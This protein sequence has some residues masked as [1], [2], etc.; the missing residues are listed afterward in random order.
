MIASPRSVAIVGGGIA[1]L[2]CAL[3]LAERGIGVTV[4]ETRRKLGGRAT[5]FVDPRTGEVLDNCQHVLMGCCTNLIDFYA[6]LGVLDAIEWHRDIHWMNPPHAPDRMRPG[7]LPAPGH[8]TWSFLRMRMLSFGEKIAVARAMWRML[9]M[10]ASGRLAWEGRAFTEFLVETRQPQRVVDVFWSP[11]VVS[12]CN[13]D[14]GEVS[15]ASAMQVFQEGF[16]ASAE[17]PL[18]GLSTV[19]LVRLYDPAEQAIAAAGGSVRLGVSARA[20]AF[21]G[22]RVTGVVTDEGMVEADA[23]VAAVPADRLA[24]LVSPT[25]VR[26]DGRLAHLEEVGSSPILGVHLRFPRTVMDLPH[27][28]LPGRGTQWLFDKGCEPDGSQHV[29]AVISGAHEWMELDEMAIAA[30]VL[31]DLRWAFPAARG[32]EPTAVRSVKEK[33]ATFAPV[34]GFDRVRPGAAASGLDRDGGVA[35]LFLAGDWSRTGWPATME[36]AVRSGYAAAGAIVG[37]RMLV[38]D[39]APAPLARILGVAR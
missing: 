22:R 15:A 19:P 11:V 13:L 4:I 17:A 28:V 12:A 18:M 14:V 27:A 35:N 9:R 1:G 25:L 2:A 10:G 26:A 31:A 38:P 20:I 34:P 36:G 23:V 21:D 32:V 8:F 24:K 7:R 37:E 3:R 16:L 39:L 6:R 30:R 29:H 5:S 33:R